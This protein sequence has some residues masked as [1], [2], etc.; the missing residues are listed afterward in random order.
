[1]FK[2]TKILCPTD[3]S[4]PSLYALCFA[5]DLAAQFDANLFVIYVVPT[6]PL[7]STPPPFTAAGI[8]GSIDL[9]AY[10]NTLIADAQKNLEEIIKT[11]LPS[12]L[13]VTP[14]IEYGDPA[15]RILHIAESLDVDLIVIAT[16]GRTGWRHLIFG[17]VAEKIIRLATKP[18]LTL[19]KPETRSQ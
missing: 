9:N 3:F 14:I 1:M 7:S 8:P 18:V 6:I 5:S 15:E 19:R 13:N 2:I 11:N 12:C 16:H 17:S 10:R 4:S